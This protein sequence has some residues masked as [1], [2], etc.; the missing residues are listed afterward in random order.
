MSETY[1]LSCHAPPWRSCC[2]SAAYGGWGDEF[3][4][5][6]VKPEYARRLKEEKKNGALGWRT[7]AWK[8][9]LFENMCIVI[10]R[11]NHAMLSA[12]TLPPLAA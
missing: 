8:Q 7:Q 1:L 12:R 6:N 5:R 11:S 4:T 2:P 9:S 10:A 3:L